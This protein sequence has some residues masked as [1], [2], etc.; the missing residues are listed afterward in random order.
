MEDLSNVEIDKIETDIMSV[1]YANMDITF[2]QFTLF[3]KLIYDKY[4]LQFNNRIHPNFKYKYLLI[5]RNL[6]S[7]YDDIKITKEKD[8]Y[9]IICLSNST[10][11]IEINKNIYSDENF[12]LLEKEDVSQ[13]YNYIY[14]NN[15]TEYINWTDPFDGNSIYHDLV[16][17]K[18]TIQIRKLIDSNNFKFLIKNKHD[19]TPIQLS[20]SKEITDILI[21][22]LTNQLEL[23]QNTYTSYEILH[24]KMLDS[25][26]TKLKYYESEEYKKKIINDTSILKY[27]YVKIYKFIDKFKIYILSALVLYI[28]IEIFIKI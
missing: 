1:L 24:N 12:N 5:L 16:I 27:S 4:N 13:L 10:K 9:S 19:Q 2:T 22:G 6:M 11:I 25:I 23:L 17:T 3:N 7:K 26:E 15:L 28:A 20:N 14:D 18:N 8:I 21:V